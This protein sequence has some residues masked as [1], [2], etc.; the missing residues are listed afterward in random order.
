MVEPIPTFT[1]TRV[2]QVPSLGIVEATGDRAMAQAYGQMGDAFG[3]IADY[4]NEK[5][6]QVTKREMARQGQEFALSKGFDPS[7]VEE[8]VTFADTVF[9]EAALNTYAIELESD[10]EK[11][12]NGLHVQHMRNPE[13]FKK[14]SEAYINSTVANLPFELRNSASKLA[15]GRADAVY[16]K[17]SLEQQR[18]VFAEQE[19]AEK[20]YIASLS[21]K[22]VLAKDPEERQ[23]LMAKLETTFQNSTTYLTPAGREQAKKEAIDN[24]LYDSEFQAVARGQKT[25]MQAMNELAE[26]GIALGS[27]QIGQLYSAINQ[28][29][30]FDEAQAARSEKRRQKSIDQ[31]SE[32]YQLDAYDMQN[33]DNSEETFAIA[34][35]TGL[36]QMRQQNATAEELIEH[37]K[38]MH[39]V[40]Y[41][42]SKQDIEASLMV[43]DQAIFDGD[44]EA[45]QI[46]RSQFTKGNIKPE[47]LQKKLQEVQQK[48]SEPV[49]NPIVQGFI[50]REFIPKY[51]PYANYSSADVANMTEADADLKRLIMRDK[52][53]V[54]EKEREL[55]DLITNEEKP[56]SYSEAVGRSRAD[57]LAN[58]T[59]VPV[60]QRIKV[61]ADNPSYTEIKNLLNSQEIRLFGYNQL[62]GR[63]NLNGENEP[64]LSGPFTE[65]N[66]QDRIKFMIDQNN[67]AK[68]VGDDPL[69][70]DEVLTGVLDAFA[71]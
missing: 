30:N 37:K 44:P 36:A 50:N 58:Q 40:F 64:L 31:I 52:Q 13:G 59:P 53:A 54:A 69:Y 67:I 43:I 34:L 57:L 21:D 63:I 45:E 1:S 22:I 39:E 47:T 20:S 14:T 68:K 56:M 6:N 42:R 12:I 32:Q 29:L 46:I 7:K 3:K 2:T 62:G 25:P 71:E 51:A 15:H 38:N 5:L 28:K 66:F 48:T 11:K 23:V 55:L 61:S 16:S 17:I 35:E 33:M 65:D 41:N 18:R 4:Q 26:S 19:A 24:I 49:Q 10:I 60:S 9:R 27:S 70:S 8:P